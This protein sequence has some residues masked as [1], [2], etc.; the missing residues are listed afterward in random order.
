M[1]PKTKR[2]NDC[3][4][5]IFGV[6]LCFCLRMESSGNAPLPWSCLFPCHLLK[7]PGGVLRVRVW[8]ACLS[9]TLKSPPSN[10]QADAHSFNL[11]AHA[12]MVARCSPHTPS[13]GST[14]AA[15]LSPSVA[16]LCL[17]FPMLS[18]HFNSHL[19]SLC[20]LENPNRGDWQIPFFL[21]FCLFEECI[22]L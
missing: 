8:V 10:D 1:F 13:E 17:T 7:P 18:C 2:I 12:V 21:C 4:V 15:T 11:P 3:S 19:A 20:L 16:L 6:L 22:D 14:Q 5:F 9:W